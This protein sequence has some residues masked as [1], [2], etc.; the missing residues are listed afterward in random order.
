[1]KVKKIKTKFTIK[2]HS[3][4]ILTS[5]LFTLLCIFLFFDSEE[6]FDESIDNFLILFLF[7]YFLNNV[8]KLVVPKKIELKKDYLEY[9]FLFVK[10]II[11]YKE[12]KLFYRKNILTKSYL[13]TD[14]QR[15]TKINIFEPKKD[16]IQEFEEAVE[17][18][19]IEANI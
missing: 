11:P 13:I 12:L 3:W 5:S 2:S 17:I 10:K 8:I 9:N 4:Q 1:L 15:R 14:N 6:I 7:V 16:F 18:K 19:I